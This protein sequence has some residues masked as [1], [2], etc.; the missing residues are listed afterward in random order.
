MVILE[1]IACGTPVVAS[2]VGGIPDLVTNNT[3]GV[4]LDDLSPKTLAT[5]IIEVFRLN[6]SANREYVNPCERSAADSFRL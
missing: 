3:N 6:I 1:A 4:V 2:N 5:A